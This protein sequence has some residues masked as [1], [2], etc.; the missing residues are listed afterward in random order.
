MLDVYPTGHLVLP[1][2]LDLGAILAAIDRIESLPAT[3][4]ASVEG[5]G[6]VDHP[7]REGAW[8]IRAL[9]HHV[10]DSH[11]NAYVRTKLLLTEPSPVVKPYDEVAWTRLGDA[12]LPVETSL[13]LIDALHVRWVE[14]LRGMGPEDLLRP[15]RIPTSA[16]PRPAW[17]IPLTYAWHGD[18]HAAQIRQAR[19]HFGL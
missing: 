8:S 5:C 12:S 2:D 11:M 6:D 17:R 14:V 4:R 7:I 3:L 16:E 19:D 13:T 10:A 1:A 18:H 15:W 9:V